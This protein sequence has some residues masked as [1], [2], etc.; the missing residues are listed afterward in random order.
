MTENTTMKS[1][2]VV[3]IDGSA[4]ARGALT[5]ALRVAR[6]LGCDLR[7]IC[8][9]QWPAGAA[10]ISAAP[11]TWNPHDDAE[12]IMADTM[13]A[14][15]VPDGVAVTAEVLHGDA[16]ELLITASRDA[17]MVVTGSTGAGMARALFLGSVST[18]VAQR[19]H[20]PVLVWRPQTAEPMPHAATD[21]PAEA[22]PALVG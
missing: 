14:L 18:R 16:A 11:L 8:A 21:A 12:A 19:A 2:I 15:E 20:C 3:G 17:R 7:I 13:T 1:T 10:M 4:V 9:W 5:E 22:V 6:E